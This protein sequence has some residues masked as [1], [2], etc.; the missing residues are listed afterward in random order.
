MNVHAY[1]QGS[2]TGG[3]VHS[4]A[5]RGKSSQRARVDAPRNAARIAPNPRV[6]LCVPPHTP[7]AAQVNGQH[8]REL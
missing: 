3:D 6:Y 5:T 4:E 2:K 8:P 7:H 1:Q